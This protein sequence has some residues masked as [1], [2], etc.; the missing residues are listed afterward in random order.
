MTTEI[1]NKILERRI[2]KIREVLEKKAEEYGPVDRLHNFK[3]SAAMLN[4]TPERAL[5]GMKVKH[6]VSVLDIV[7]QIERDGTVPT[8]EMLDEKIG[9]LINYAILLEVAVHER[10]TEEEFISSPESSD[11]FDVLYKE[12]NA[13]D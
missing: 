4:C 7:D 3:R 11:Y 12:P 9:D 13:T 2:S 10:A 6:D 8:L 5:V 1:F